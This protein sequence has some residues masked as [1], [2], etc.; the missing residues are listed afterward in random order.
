M[1]RYILVILGILLSAVAALAQS[2]SLLDKV[3]GHRVT[4]D[5]VY[6]LEKDGRPMSEVTRGEALVEDNCYVLTGLG[7]K[8]YSDGAT[9][10]S[11]DP[12]AKE[13]L[14]ET[15]DKEDVFTNPALF[16]GAYKSYRERITVLSSSKDALS[17]TLRLDEDA[18]V[19]FDLSK[20]RFEPLQGREG[21]SPD[22][23]FFG[24]DYQITDL[25]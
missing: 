5:Y 24:Q 1:N 10:V 23:S 21:F 20:V 2:I 16:I 7:L 4:F 15:V 11:I 3:P 19:R 14:V 18:L 6:S 8:I 12:D 22:L 25:R 17:V 9:R 13:V